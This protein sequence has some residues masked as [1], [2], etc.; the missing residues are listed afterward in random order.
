MNNQIWM[1][2][3]AF[4]PLDLGQI[5]S[6]TKETATPCRRKRHARRKSEPRAQAP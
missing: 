2:T 1:M 6:K 3:S 4:K 5:V